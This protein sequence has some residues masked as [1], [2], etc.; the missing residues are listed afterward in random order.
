MYERDI[1]KTI[2]RASKL[3]SIESEFIDEILLGPEFSWA[4]E[5][6]LSVIKLRDTDK[7]LQSRIILNWLR[8]LSVSDI[9]TAEVDLVRTLLEKS[10]PAKINLPRGKY[11][12]RRN[13]LIFLED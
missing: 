1:S 7:A 13:K 6:N 12:R 3:A 8:R 2:L 11:V 5:I 10:G 9:G 4:L